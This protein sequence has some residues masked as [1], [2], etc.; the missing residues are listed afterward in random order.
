MIETEGLGLFIDHHG[1]D[2]N[3]RLDRH[4]RGARL[5]GKHFGVRL[6]SRP[7]GKKGNLFAVFETFER[8]HHRTH[9]VAV[10]VDLYRLELFAEKAHKPIVDD[11]FFREVMDSLP[12]CARGIN[13]V[14][15]PIM[16]ANIDTRSVLDLALAV[17]AERQTQPKDGNDDNP[18]EIEPFP[19]HVCPFYSRAP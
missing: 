5:E 2:G 6:I 16:I 14:P 17:K 1:Y 8:V 11:G 7:F 9:V 19:S 13:N 4:D 18:Q 10:A 12:G 3:L 15:Y